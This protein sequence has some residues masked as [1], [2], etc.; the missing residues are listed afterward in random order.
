MQVLND[1]D[2]MQGGL[3]FKQGNVFWLNPKETE[4][5]D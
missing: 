5:V 2:I 1:Q 3:V 4:Y